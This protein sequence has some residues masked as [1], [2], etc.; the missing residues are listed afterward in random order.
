[1]S[2][3]YEEL[4]N[5]LKIECEQMK[6]DNDE[7][8]NEY[9]S[10]IQMLT[11]SIENNKKEK[12]SLQTKINN[13]EK[14]KESLQTKINNLEKEIKKF[15]KER[16]SLINKNK[17]KIIDIQNLTSANEKVKE[18]MKKMSEK[19]HLIKANVITLE[20]DNDHYQNKIRQNEAL[21]EDLTSQ[22][23]SALEEN[24]T[25]QTEFELY[26]QQNEE[27]LVRKDQ[28]IKDIQND[29]SNKEKII[30]RLNDKRA[31]I[32][33]LK[34]TFQIPKD[35][36]KQYQRQLTNSIPVNELIENKKKEENKI[37][38][39]SVKV[40]N[41]KLITPLS[42]STTKFPAKF[43][44]IYRKSIGPM[45][46][47]LI[48]KK[49]SVRN[50]IDLGKSFIKDGNLIDNKSS[51]DILSRTNTLKEKSAVDGDVEDKNEK[52]EIEEDE[53]DSTASDKKCFEDLVI[54]D[55]KDFNIIPIK[56]LM[57]E[58]KK[59]KNQKLVDN[60]KSMLTRIQKRK[61]ILIKHQKDN[62]K[63]L[64]KMGFKVKN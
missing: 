8:C 40:E 64:E 52:E 58:S 6:A 50:S 21:I 46:N 37:I 3:N 26:K 59:I 31:S 33:E 57:N 34:Q 44:E 63:K 60:L 18:D 24:I 30:K 41:N 38:Q 12:E 13:I 22:L 29:L 48:Q 23:E 61:E 42:D 17:E 14:E 25:L 36:I 7:I 5:N 39:K 27:S 49:E 15:E 53:N 11:E 2:Q 56:K 28:E 51:K 4:Y 19:F 1:M 47:Q 35:I 43:M 20:N 10:T 16:E 45:N 55:E 32:R 54:C 9:E 62:N